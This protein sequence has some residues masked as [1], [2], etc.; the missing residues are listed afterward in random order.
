MGFRH[1]MS[2]LLAAAAGI[3]FAGCGGGSSSTTNTT[4]TSSTTARASGSSGV[5]IKDFKFAPA[6]LTVDGGT[7]L[8]VTN[9][10][11]TAHTATADAGGAFDTGTID[12][13]ASKTFTLEKPGRYAYHCSIHPFMHGTI[14]V[15]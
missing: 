1:Y 2:P 5:S 11:S 3:A 10:D 6:T 13:G 4:T 14:V 12:T 9:D 8:T 7:R 15:R